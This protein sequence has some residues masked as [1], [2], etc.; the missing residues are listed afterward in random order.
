MPTGWRPID[1]EFKYPLHTIHNPSKQKKYHTD[2]ST[3]FIIWSFIQLYIG[4]FFM[5]H[6]FSILHLQNSILNY[7]YGLFIMIHIFSFTSALDQKKYSTT[8]EIIKIL[9]VFGL[10]YFQSF[11]WFGLNGL[12]IYLLI[13][14]LTLSYYLST[15][16]YKNKRVLI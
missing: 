13:F 15:H 8:V 14:Y 6:F 12:Y 7:S 3:S 10:L 4:I 9:L 1:V 11:S 2:L 16:F 5:L